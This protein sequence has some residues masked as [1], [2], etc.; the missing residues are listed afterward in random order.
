MF[1]VFNS[2]RQV[3]LRI[4]TLFVMAAICISIELYEIV[5]GA[6][7]FAQFDVYC[8][9]ICA[10]DRLSEQI[11]TFVVKLLIDC[12]LAA[13]VRVWRRCS[14]AVDIVDRCRPDVEGGLLFRFFFWPKNLLSEL[15]LIRS[16]TV[17][18]VKQTSMY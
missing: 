2:N 15:L 16:N 1:F 9:C 18:Q 7:H 17:C 11:L 13:D 12:R 10:N 6:S 5:D 3:A 4:N 8:A 14:I